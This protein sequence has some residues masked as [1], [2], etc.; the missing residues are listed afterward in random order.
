MRRLIYL[1]STDNILPCS[2]L[3]LFG[4]GLMGQYGFNW[5]DSMVK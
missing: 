5:N 3:A 4:S 1:L 2:C